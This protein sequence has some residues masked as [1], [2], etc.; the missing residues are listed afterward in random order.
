MLSLIY[1]ILYM[2]LNMTNQH[3]KNNLTLLKEA[4]REK[5]ITDIRDILKSMENIQTMISYYYQV[6]KKG[7]SKDE[8]TELFNEI[9]KPHLGDRKK[10]AQRRPKTKIK[11]YESDLREIIENRDKSTKDK[12]IYILLITGRRMA[13]II[14]DNIPIVKDNK[15]YMKLSKKGEN[16]E[17]EEIKI[18][19]ETAQN[20]KKMIIEIK[21]H[22]FKIN[23]ISNLLIKKLRRYDLTPHNLRGIYVNLIYKFY[24]PSNKSKVGIGTIYL[25]HSGAQNVYDYIEYDGN[26]PFKANISNLTSL[27]MKELKKIAKEK[28]LK[29]Y[30]RLRKPELIKLILDS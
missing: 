7:F 27:N 19:N 8:L 16:N 4:V 13:D 3:K 28:K 17:P 9:I 1:M 2:T 25:N 21:N 23:T 30:S 18:L 10:E 14:N 24:N 5:N 22:G 12:L 20:V 29:K 15:L 6:V 11:V 26:N